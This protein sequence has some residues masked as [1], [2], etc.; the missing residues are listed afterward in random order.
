M[1]DALSFRTAAAAAAVLLQLGA[2]VA[3]PQSPGACGGL[4]APC[5]SFADAGRRCA[6]AA[7]RSRLVNVGAAKPLPFA[8]REGQDDPAFAACITQA[9]YPP[10]VPVRVD[11][12]PR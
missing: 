1:H 6:Q 10:S 12:P 7:Q 3:P 2:C 11:W 9:G 5:E 4:A 8:L